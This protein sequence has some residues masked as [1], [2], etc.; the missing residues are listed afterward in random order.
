MFTLKVKELI[1]LVLVCFEREEE[2]KERRISVFFFFYSLYF[3]K[4]T[5]IEV[6]NDYSF[7]QKNV[8]ND[9]F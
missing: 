4:W 1:S 3:L 2:W 8:Y 9:L 6:I 5:K 7:R